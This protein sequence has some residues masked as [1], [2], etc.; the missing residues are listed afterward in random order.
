MGS[1]SIDIASWEASDPHY[2]TI[3]HLVK[4]SCVMLKKVDFLLKEHVTSELFGK[5]QNIENTQNIYICLL[6]LLLQS[7]ARRYTWAGYKR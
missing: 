7:S 1:S 2:S 5:T 3:N 6:L 4:L